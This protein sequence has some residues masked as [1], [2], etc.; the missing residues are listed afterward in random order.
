VNG[1]RQSLSL[2]HPS[3]IQANRVHVAKTE[4]NYGDTVIFCGVRWLNRRNVPS[5]I[6]TVT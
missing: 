4:S 2:A 5:L 3:Y 6:S 1:E